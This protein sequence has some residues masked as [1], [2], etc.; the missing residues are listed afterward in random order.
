MAAHAGVP[1]TG[2]AESGEKQ[3]QDS[4]GSLEDLVWGRGMNT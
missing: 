3:V 4:L 1:A 2:E